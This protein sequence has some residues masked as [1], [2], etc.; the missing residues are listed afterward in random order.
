MDKE[1]QEKIA[2]L[3]AGNTRDRMTWWCW[4][5]YLKRSNQIL[6]VLQELGYRKLPDKPPLLLAPIWFNFPESIPLEVVSKNMET[7]R[8]ADIKHYTK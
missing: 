3:A 1:A 8:E 5:E 2:E 7:Q 6:Q 4:Q